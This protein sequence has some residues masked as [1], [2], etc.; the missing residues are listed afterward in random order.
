MCHLLNK[1]PQQIHC[2][3]PLQNG[4]FDDQIFVPPMHRP[5]LNAQI[6]GT[7]LCCCTRTRNDSKFPKTAFVCC[8]FVM[9]Y[10][11]Y[12]GYQDERADP[13]MR[14]CGSNKLEEMKAGKVVRSRKK[15]IVVSRN[16]DV[17]CH[18]SPAKVGIRITC[19]IEDSFALDEEMMDLTYCNEFGDVKILPKI[20]N[21]LE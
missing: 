20:M 7:S 5:L 8:D 10:F 17:Q 19:N 4:S 1:L 9:K 11:F 6:S 12:S 2:T 21:D 14:L 18:K 16:I 3:N 13:S 15:R